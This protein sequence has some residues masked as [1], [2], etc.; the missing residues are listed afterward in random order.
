MDPFSQVDSGSLADLITLG[1]ACAPPY[2][3]ENRDKLRRCKF[4]NKTAARSI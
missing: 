3:E 2:D 4:M 1:G